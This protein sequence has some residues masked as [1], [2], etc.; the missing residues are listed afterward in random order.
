MRP[1]KYLLCLDIE[2]LMDVAKKKREMYAM[3]FT[4]LIQH[5]ICKLDIFTLFTCQ[6]LN[7]DIKNISLIVSEKCAVDSLS[8][9]H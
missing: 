6:I 9:T 8:N 4:T 5:D 2:I 3:T 1:V 7:E